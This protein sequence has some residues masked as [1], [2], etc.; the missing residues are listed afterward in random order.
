[1]RLQLV[2]N[3][4]QQYASLLAAF[5]FVV[6]QYNLPRF[7]VTDFDTEVCIS[8]HRLSLHIVAGHNLV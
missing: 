7:K 4:Y 8:H 6:I 1:M 2:E 5:G 3:M